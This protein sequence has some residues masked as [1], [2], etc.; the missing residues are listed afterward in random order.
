M[1]VQAGPDA[2]RWNWSS[3]TPASAFPRRNC[4]VSSIASIASR[5]RAAARMEGT[6]IGL[7]L[8]HELVRLH[9]GTIGVQ[10]QPGAGTTIRIA[11]PFGHVHLPGGA[12]SQDLGRTM[13]EGTA[14]ASFVEE[15]LRWLPQTGRGSSLATRLPGSTARCAASAARCAPRA[16]VRHRILLADDNADMRDY[17]VRL[18]ARAIRCGGRAATARRRCAPSSTPAPR[19]AAQRCDDAAARRL[20]PVGRGPR[21]PAAARHAGDLLSARAGEEAQVEGLDAG[22]DD[23]L[24]KPFAARELLARVRSNLELARI[25][26]E[27]ADQIREEAHRL[28]VLNRT[29]TAIAAELDLDRLVQAV[30]DAA[31]ELTGAHVRCVFLQCDERA[32]ANP[33]RCTRYP[34]RRAKRSPTFRCRATPRC[35]IRHSTG[36]GI[37]RSDDIRLR[38]ALRSEPAVSSACRMAICRCAAIW[39][40]RW[41]RVPAKC[42]AACSSAIPM[43]AVF[44]ARDELIVCGIAAQAA[45]GIDNAR[46]YRASRQARGQACVAQ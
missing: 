28:E 45:I 23:Y 14:A 5:A 41:F 24:V 26:R 36:E 3:A 12:G 11:L 44:T 21:R 40:C 4:R 37:V 9:G 25:R 10:S 16:S 34:A 13:P 33:T 35:S 20:R 39:P 43:P 19:P 31:V 30:T 15:A 29:G 7:A 2:Q 42:W 18:L 6:G 22:A 17:V 32:P 27:A 38:S 46:L 1:T 8:V